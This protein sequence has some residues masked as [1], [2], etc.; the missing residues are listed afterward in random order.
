MWMENWLEVVL[1][2]YNL[3]YYQ[4]L[5]TFLIN[6]SFYI[7]DLELTQQ[8]IFRLLILLFQFQSISLPLL[9]FTITSYFPMS[10]YPKNTININ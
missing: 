8:V 5:F 2:G 10:K 7:G 4:R 6:P 3:K 1:D 9:W